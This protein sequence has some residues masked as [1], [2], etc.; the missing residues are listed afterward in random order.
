MCNRLY[1]GT[2]LYG[3]DG[4]HLNVVLD[5]LCVKLCAKSLG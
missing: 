1:D 4:Y 5:I 3:P 2:L